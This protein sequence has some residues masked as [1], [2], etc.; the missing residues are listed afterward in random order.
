MEITVIENFLE[1]EQQ[2]FLE[3]LLIFSRK[4]PYYYSNFTTE[5]ISFHTDQVKDTS[6]FVHGFVNYNKKIS[7][8][9]EHVE[10]II[11]K[12]SS[13]L[14][15]DMYIIRFKANIT[16]PQQDY[17]KDWFNGPHIDTPFKEAISVIYYVNDSDGDTVFFNE[18]NEIYKAVSPKKG[19]LVY[20]NNDIKHSGKLPF[21]NNLRVLLNISLLPTKYIYKYKDRL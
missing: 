3:N 5:K 4:V 16:Y 18:K 1:K 7:T 10:H 2:D 17:E 15:E 13:L 11:T 14:N 6:Q 12:L 9:W 21:E 19:T 20:F 8:K